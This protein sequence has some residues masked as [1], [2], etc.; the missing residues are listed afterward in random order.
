MNIQSQKIEG[1][2]YGAI[3]P[4]LVLRF[5]DA[6]IDTDAVAA[7]L[8]QILET[9][10]LSP[11]PIDMVG[12]DLDVDPTA[13]TTRFVTLVDA[14]NRL[15][16]D[17][18]FTPIQVFKQG[19]WLCFAIPTLSSDLSLLNSSAIPALVSNVGA[20]ISRQHVSAFVQAQKQRARGFLPLGTNAGNLIAAAAERH[21]PFRIFNLRYL[22]FGYGR[23]AR[24]FN[25]SITDQERA[26][27]VAL[28]K[29][30]VDTNRLLRMAGV[31]VPLQMRVRTVD[32]A[33]QAAKRVGYPLVL[34]PENQEQGRGVFANILD[35][36]ELRDCFET[37]KVYKALIIE[38]FIQGFGYRVQVHHGQVLDAWRMDPPSIAGDGVSTIHALIQRENEKP[39]RH[40]IQSSLNPIPLDQIT[41]V[42]LQKRGLTLE[43][44]LDRGVRVTLAATSNESRGGS[45]HRFISRLH[46]D[47]AKLCVQA[48]QTLGLQ[49]AGVDLI[50]TDAAVSWRHN[51]TVVCE[52][53]SQPQLGELA[54]YPHLYRDLMAQ[55]PSTVTPVELQISKKHQQMSLDVFNKARS[56]VVI[57]CAPQEILSNGCPTQ[58]VTTL[59]FG[60]D[61]S[62][63]DEKSIRA[64][65]VSVF[66]TEV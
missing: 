12:R 25:S 28:A 33:V 5:Q 63:E 29:S 34:K 57:Q 9:P 43:S 35:E 6:L 54:G 50:S 15:C 20:G 62:V 58:Y 52:V 47:N 55:I 59:S 36:A 2:A 39:E 41:R 60:R 65:L 38:A 64:M 18:R 14:L 16:G 8:G 4:S 32:E 21:L 17:Q 42:N 48:A 1:Y 10:P 22:I 31:P 56:K 24:I 44:V 13:W 26:I 3:Q 40:S 45:P 46:P 27:G 23:N 11:E 61:V 19:Q 53:N 30:K 49:I 37:A 7:V 51:N 66:P